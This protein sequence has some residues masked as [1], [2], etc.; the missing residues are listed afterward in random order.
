MT[1]IA[2]CLC[3]DNVP[4]RVAS[5]RIQCRM[6]WF[7]SGFIL[8]DGSLFFSFSIFASL[9]LTST[10]KFMVVYQDYSEF[11]PDHNHTRLSLLTRIVCA[12]TKVKCQREK[13]NTMHRLDI[14]T[15][16]FNYG[17]L[18]INYNTH[19]G[20]SRRSTADSGHLILVLSCQ[21]CD[22]SKWLQQNSIF[23]N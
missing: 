1:A 12:Q 20:H 5:H 23:T 15:I 9:F 4:H 6:M 21:K 8:R 22:S 7:K 11:L 3:I 16:S 13:N 14:P 19:T 18:C 17:D 10:S 2:I